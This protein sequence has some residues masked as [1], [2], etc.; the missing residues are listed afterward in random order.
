MQKIILLTSVFIL[1]FS[2]KENKQ[3]PDIGADKASANET[4]NQVEINYA[5][6]FTINKYDGYK[7][8]TLKEPWPDADIEFKYAL[9]E[10]KG[11]LPE[12]ATFDAV[13]EVPIKNIVVTS[14]THIPSLE[15]LEETDALVGFPN[16]SYIS[17]EETRKRIDKNEIKEL[18]KNES[19]NTE[20]LIDLNPNLVVTFAVKGDNKTVSTIEKTG[21]PVFYNSDWTEKSPLGK[22]E[23]IKFFGALFNKEQQADSIFKSIE[24]D[25][26]SVKEKAAQTKTSPTVLS[27]AM[28]KDV[29]Y[30]PNGE[31][32]GAQFIKDAHATY[33]WEDTKGTGS[34]SLNLESVLE[35]AKDA[36]VW[37]GPGQFS[38]KEK[39]NDAHAVYS[40]FK[41]FQE[42]NVY[43]YTGKLGPTGG[44]IYFELAP[45][46]PDLV[47]KDVVKIV[48]P[49]VLPEHELYFFRKLK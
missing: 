40:E 46:R 1:L 47:L 37:L 13:V 45:N 24:T 12:D 17:S 16:L 41:A 29:W 25:Y 42:G 27:G 33:L 3:S 31:S 28:Y 8:I 26:L 44:V 14:T 34:L 6:G 48:H 18:G 7:V 20:V 38:E 22:A 2:C 19:I 35:K 11:S 21:I 9:I 4:K 32:W 10:E 36:D 5:K 15:M 39:L 23:W 43:S 30:L 49:E